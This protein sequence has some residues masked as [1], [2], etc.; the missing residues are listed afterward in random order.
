MNKRIR[1]YQRNFTGGWIWILVTSV[2]GIWLMPALGQGQKEPETITR[3]PRD[4][5]ADHRALQSAA[6]AIAKGSFDKARGFMSLLS[7]EGSQESTAFQLQGILDAQTK[8][9]E[10]VNVARQ[11]AYDEYLA[12]ME[13]EVQLA[14]W[15][16]KIL[17]TSTSH[18][19]QGEVKRL[20]ETQWQEEIREHWLEALMELRFAQDL[21]KRTGLA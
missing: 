12:T 2:V 14:L 5:S 16:E 3:P 13:E 18:D 19:W 17:S 9:D 8:L 20:T 10:Q 1:E 15:R 6:K 7:T 4:P 11:S 21:V